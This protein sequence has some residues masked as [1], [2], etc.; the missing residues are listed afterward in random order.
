MLFRKKEEVVLHVSNMHC[1][2]CVN[3]IINALKKLKVKASGDLEKQTIKVIYDSQKVQLETIKNKIIE[4]G[5]G[6]E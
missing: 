1:I 3:K 4:L 6:I 2:H 5:Y